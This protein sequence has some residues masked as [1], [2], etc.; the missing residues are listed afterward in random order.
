MRPVDR[1]TL[2]ELQLESRS[3]KEKSILNFFDHTK[4]EGGREILKKL[5]NTPKKSIEEINA[6]QSL[7][8]FISRCSDLWTLNFPRVYIAASE[9]YYSSNIAYSMSQDVFQHYWDTFIFSWR[10]PA[11]FYMIRSGLVATLKMVRCMHEFTSRFDNVE[12]PEAASEDFDFLRNFLHSSAIRSFLKTEDHKLTRRH[13]FYQDYYF[14]ISYKKSFRR[15]LDIFYTFDAYLSIALT[16]Q[17]NGLSFPVFTESKSIFEADE[18]WHP[19][20]LNPVPNI[21]ELNKETFLCLISGANTSGK[22]TFLKACG[23]S[24]YLAHL[25]WPVPAVK[26]Q[27]SWFDELFTSVHLSDNLDLG[28]SHFYNEIMRIKIIAEALNSGT[29]CMVIIDEL[30]RGTNLE[31]A[32]ACSRLVINGFLNYPGSVFLVSTH[33]YELL[34]SFNAENNISFRCFRT[35]LT[36]NDFENTYQI[37]AGIASEKIGQLILNKSGIPGLLH[38]NITDQKTLE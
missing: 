18:L 26:L 9:N 30:F 34:E 37:E 31:D 38:T 21:F 33:L 3:G 12:I 8:K 10:N 15:V 4:S 11:E 7:L 22:T 23:I 36:E 20:V 14:R 2:H 29:K 25:G 28:Y 27:L 19:L 6:F 24:I 13:V 5:L 16:Q 1:Q 35:V 17:Q 32:Y